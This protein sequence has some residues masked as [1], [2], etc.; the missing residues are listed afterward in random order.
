MA[1]MFQPKKQSLK[2]NDYNKS[3]IKANDKLKSR[4]KTLESSIKAQEKELKSLDKQR[5]SESKKLGKLLIEVD[6]QEDRFQKLKGAISSNEKLLTGKLNKVGNAEKELCDYESAVEK[7]EDREGKLKDDIKALE[8]YKARCSESKD[9]LAGIQVKKDNA[10]DE[11]KDIKAEIDQ[12]YVDRN[13]KVLSYE[14]QY[15]DLEEKAKSH[16]DMVCRFEQ[17]LFDAKDQALSEENKL[18]DIQSKDKKEKKK[19]DDELQAVKNLV[20]NTE[21]EYIK[22]E[23]KIDRAKVK[24]D[25]EIERNKKAKESFEKWRIVVLEEVARLKLKS[26]VENIDKA[27]LSEILNG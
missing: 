19:I 12:L 24:A 15:N 6:F 22:W 5:T 9:E 14:S 1:E 20:G 13:S 18:K 26:K 8:F 17:R 16:E 23:V 2:K 21:D 3:V 27:G 10:L 25:K 7:L 4:N 11:L